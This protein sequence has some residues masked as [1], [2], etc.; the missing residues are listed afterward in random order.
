LLL[1]RAWAEVSEVVGALPELVIG[2]RERVCGAGQLGIGGCGGGG[3]GG[4]GVV[5]GGVER[6][7][8]AVVP[9]DSAKR[10]GARRPVDCYVLNRAPLSR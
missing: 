8:A 9:L 7:V 5:R 6:K 4:C 3:C 2:G 1:R 10:F